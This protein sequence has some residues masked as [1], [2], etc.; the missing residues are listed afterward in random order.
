MKRF[1][2][3]NINLILY[4]FFR[5]INVLF[6]AVFSSIFSITLSTSKPCLCPDK[7]EPV[8]GENGFTYT[9]ACVM[10]CEWV[11]LF[12]LLPLYFHE[13]SSRQMLYSL[14]Q[15]SHSFSGVA[16]AQDP[17]FCCRCELTYNP[18]C[19]TNGKSYGNRCMASCV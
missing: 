11:H 1:H 5:M 17:M 7:D 18:V 8:C 2:F 9:N 10:K 4:A 19:G 14:R 3:Q 12:T 13:N 6:L 16:A 15:I